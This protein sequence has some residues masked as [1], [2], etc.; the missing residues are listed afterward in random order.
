MFWNVKA[1]SVV[2][3]EISFL[4]FFRLLG[5]QSFDT[6]GHERYSSE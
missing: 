3:F 2:P 5:F 1:R 6:N 4:G